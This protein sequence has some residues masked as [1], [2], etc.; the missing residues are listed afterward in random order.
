[1][2][3]KAANIQQRPEE[4]WLVTGL[5]SVSTWKMRKEKVGRQSRFFKTAGVGVGR[6]SRFFKTAGVGVGRRSRFFKTAGVGV[7]SRNP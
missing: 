5:P 4:R 2:T 3:L 6:R 7:R 1:M